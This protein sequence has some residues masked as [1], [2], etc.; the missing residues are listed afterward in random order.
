MTKILPGV[1]HAIV[2]TPKKEDSL[3]MGGVFA[4][5]DLCFGPGDEDAIRNISFKKEGAGFVTSVPKSKLIADGEIVYQPAL[6]GQ[7]ASTMVAAASKALD[8]VRS[9]KGLKYNKSY[10]VFAN[11][12][13]EIGE[14]KANES[15]TSGT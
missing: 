6:I 13:E 10:R 7:V 14:V 4:Y 2:R 11:S 15:A 12:V 3:A 5:V 1:T 9:E 8:R